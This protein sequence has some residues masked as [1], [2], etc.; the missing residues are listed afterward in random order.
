M[1]AEWVAGTVLISLFVYAISGALLLLVYGI[2]RWRKVPFPN[3]NVAYLIG[4]IFIMGGV[5]LRFGVIQNQIHFVHLA[6]FFITQGVVMM[7]L[8]YYKE[9]QSN[10]S[11]F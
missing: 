5:S 9:K 11:I 10:P 1:I 8:G 2:F 6:L 7:A 4:G 3:Y